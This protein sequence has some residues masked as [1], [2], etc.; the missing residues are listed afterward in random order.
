MSIVDNPNDKGIGK[1][2]ENNT[3]TELDSLAY[4]EAGEPQEAK[5]QDEGSDLPD[6]YKGKS[7]ADI[8]RMHQEL[9]QKFGQQ[10]NEVGELRR[11]LDQYILNRLQDGTQ[12]GSAQEEEEEDFFEDPKKSVS[13]AISNDPEI[14]K[15]KEVAA[16]VEQQALLSTLKSKHGDYEQLLQDSKF[17]EWVKG[18]K[19]RQRMLVEA[20]RNYDIEAAD[21]LFS[22]YKSTLKSN[23]D[24]TVAAEKQQRQAE[25]KRA[26]TGTARGKSVPR[27]SKKV[28]RRA[29]IIDLMKNNPDRYDALMPEIRKAYEEGRVR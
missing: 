18:S 5:T 23:A 3:E 11:T 10:G 8:A 28:Y 16:R 29:D 13:K 20:D 27:S 4:E 24:E 19:I 17:Q 15:L 25:I 9:E 14:K 26:S 2:P 21:E 6:K 22:E 12:N 1:N 7:A